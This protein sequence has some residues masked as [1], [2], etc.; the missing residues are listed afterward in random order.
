[1]PGSRG[2]ADA[3][4]AEYRAFEGVIAE[5]EYGA[6]AVIVW[7]EGAYENLSTDEDGEPV[8]L[9]EALEHGHAS[10][11]LAGRK[12][13][14]GYALTRVRGG[15]Y[16]A[17]PLVKQADRYAS[18]AGTPDPRRARSART[19]HTLRQVAEEAGNRS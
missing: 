4:L 6:G 3:S 18:R 12:L 19:G 1:M 9:A 10:F 5:G 13:H 11:R 17:W 7:D 14:G 8:P 16:P 15:E 2:T